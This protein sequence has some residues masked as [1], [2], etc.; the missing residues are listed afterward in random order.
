MELSR[1]EWMR[2]MYLTDEMAN[3]PLCEPF[4]NAQTD[5][6]PRSSSQPTEFPKNAMC[7]MKVK[8]RLESKAYCTV[9]GWISDVESIWLHAIKTSPPSSP[10]SLIA[11]D[12]LHWFRR[13]LAST[14]WR[15]PEG[16]FVRLA[17]AAKQMADLAGRPPNDL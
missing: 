10:I 2:C 16:E 7:L 3:R 8:E 11:L 17:K 15:G 6:Y 4:L 5:F 12:L 14:G 9:S 13:K 1:H